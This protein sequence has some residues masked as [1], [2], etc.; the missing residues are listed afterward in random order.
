MRFESPERQLLTWTWSGS[1]L[2]LPR[3]ISEPPALTPASTKGFI[4]DFADR[5]C[6][7]VDLHAP[8]PS[9]ASHLRSNRKC[10]PSLSSLPRAEKVVLCQGHLRSKHEGRETSHPP[11]PSFLKNQARQETFLG[12]CGRS[13]VVLPQVAVR[14]CEQRLDPQSP[15]R[16]LDWQSC[17]GL[18]FSLSRTVCGAW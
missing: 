10:A 13:R 16:D 8:S 3:E 15:E 5:Q 2:N 14:A 1:I 18:R 17:P 4:A 7:S 11:A 6:L 9:H 12:N